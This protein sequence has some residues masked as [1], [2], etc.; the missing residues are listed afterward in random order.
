MRTKK[1]VEKVIIPNPPTWKRTIVM[2]C[3]ASERS[4]PI[5]MVANPVTH[6]AD[7]AV[8]RASTNPSRPFAAEKGKERSQVPSRM[9][10]AKP[11]MKVRSGLICLERKGLIRTGFLLGIALRGL[12][13][14]S[15]LLVVPRRN[16]QRIPR[17]LA[18]HGEIRGRTYL[19]PTSFLLFELFVFCMLF[20]LKRKSI[21][22]GK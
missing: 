18:C 11:R 15:H 4:L 12:I 6:T 22:G 9:Q 5:S 20:P 13:R 19:S 14:P 7:V 21:P 16:P 1:T 3:P 8:N 17:H 10:T 2:I